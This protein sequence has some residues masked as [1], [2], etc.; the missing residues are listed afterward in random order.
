[1]PAR[2]L[3]WLTVFFMLGIS[4]YRLVGEDL[5]VQTHHFAFAA[6]I[7][8]AAMFASLCFSSR[9]RRRKTEDRGQKTEDVL[10]GSIT[11]PAMVRSR[12]EAAPTS[13][14]HSPRLK[15]AFG[16]G[17]ILHSLFTNFAIPALLFAL[18]GVWA[19]RSAAPQFP[20]GL[21][22]F[23][24]GNP[25]TFIAKVSTSTTVRASSRKLI[26][27]GFSHTP[28]ELNHNQC[29]ILNFRRAYGKLPAF[30]STDPAVTS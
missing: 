27:S 1:M 7:L 12:L 23:L 2:P 17:S 25:A 21:E 16:A 11:L 14:G 4:A 22:P 3:F 18:F 5:P 19:A 9:S 13:R 10:P 8:I 29:Q 28:G 26:Y 20:L 15:H 30:P 24:N 6:L